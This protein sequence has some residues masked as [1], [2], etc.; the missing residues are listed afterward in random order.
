METRHEE[1]QTH[2]R[3][4]S[5][6]ID[7]LTAFSDGRRLLDETSQNSIV[8][9]K[10]MLLMLQRISDHFETFTKSVHEGPEDP[11]APE[12]P[13]GELWWPIKEEQR[14]ENEML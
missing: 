2:Y 4:I 5:H 8:E 7:F 9:L 1:F 13:Q 3:Y 6:V 14:E 10:R 11:F 12:N